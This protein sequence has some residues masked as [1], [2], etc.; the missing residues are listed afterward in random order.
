MSYQLSTT[1]TISVTPHAH[2]DFTNLTVGDPIS[3]CVDSSGNGN[4]LVQTTSGLTVTTY[5]TA[6][7]P[8]SAGTCAWFPGNAA[9]SGNCSFTS[10]SS[11][12]VFIGQHDLTREYN[13]WGAMVYMI[14][15][16]ANSWWSNSRG[17]VGL[18]KTGSA[19]HNIATNGPFYNSNEDFHQTHVNSIHMTQSVDLTNNKFETELFSKL[20]A[21]TPSNGLTTLYGSK[22]TTIQAGYASTTAT[23]RPLTH[24]YVGCHI[25][26][27]YTA[28]TIDNHWGGKCSEI[29][30]FDEP[31][32][33]AD[34]QIMDDYIESRYN[35]TRSRLVGDNCMNFTDPHKSKVDIHTSRDNPNTFTFPKHGGFDYYQGYLKAHFWWSMWVKF[36]PVL[37]T[38]TST[39]APSGYRYNQSNPA[40]SVYRRIM[41]MAGD[42]RDTSN[43]TDLSLRTDS[44]KPHLYSWTLGGG[45][46][47]T[48]TAGGTRQMEPDRWFHVL[49]TCVPERV[50]DPTLNTNRN[51]SHKIAVYVDGLLSSWKASSSHYSNVA[52]FSNHIRLGARDRTYPRHDSTDHHPGFIGQIAN[53][54][55]GVG[56]NPYGVGDPGMTDL[57]AS[58]N[59][60]TLSALPPPFERVNIIK[61][62]D[63]VSQTPG[64]ENRT[65]QADYTVVP[66]L[67]SMKL[68]DDVPL[69]HGKRSIYSGRSVS[70]VRWSQY[71][72]SGNFSNTDFHGL[73]GTRFRKS[74]HNTHLYFDWNQLSGVEFC[75]EWFQFLPDEPIYINSNGYQLQLRNNQLETLSGFTGSD[76]SGNSKYSYSYFDYN[77]I[78]STDGVE[79][80]DKHE[81]IYLGYNRISDISSLVNASTAN[82]CI[83]LSLEGNRFRELPTGV[84]QNYK[85]LTN[86]YLTSNSLTSIEGLEPWAPKLAQV[87]VNTQWYTHS[88]VDAGYEYAP[89][90]GFE[91]LFTSNAM[92]TI[93]ANGTKWET[94]VIPPMTGTNLTFLDFSHSNLTDISNL[95]TNPVA[96]V[97]MYNTQ[98]SLCADEV[99][100]DS[101]FL[102]NNPDLGNGSLG[103][104]AL[105]GRNISVFNRLNL[106]GTQL[107]DYRIFS[108]SWDH[109]NRSYWYSARG[110]I[111]YFRCSNHAANTPESLG[112]FKN[113]YQ[114]QTFYGGAYSSTDHLTAGSLDEMFTNTGLNKTRGDFYDKRF[115]NYM[116]LNY[117]HLTDV[118]WLSA[119][120]AAG[121][122]YLYL[123]YTPNLDYQTWEA[124]TP[125]LVALKQAGDI[126]L[127]RI[128]LTGSLWDR[129]HA[130]G[131]HKY[132]EYMNTHYPTNPS[133]HSYSRWTLS[134]RMSGYHYDAQWYPNL[135]LSAGDNF[136][137]LCD[138]VSGEGSSFSTQAQIKK[139]LWDA[140]IKMGFTA[141]NTDWH[142]YLGL[143]NVA[144]PSVCPRT[145]IL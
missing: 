109:P 105:S 47:L 34:Q 52:K 123:E 42:K 117:S 96:D 141:S 125:T 82:S 144:V 59:N 65:N 130:G 23:Y 106:Q 22:N 73:S 8:S 128:F 88:A 143:Y 3:A 66:Y 114:M 135:Y 32:S 76:F 139:D 67:S 17:Q 43:R 89:M 131:G 71:L 64:G 112:S 60:P 27:S 15:A 107:S 31:L 132:Q 44:G 19:I 138:G 115:C 80:L 12:I 46:S 118:S 103:A 35:T 20:S 99:P 75:R 51:G 68:N 145:T 77:N 4:N 85:N 87:R 40:T 136:Y 69:V 48:S 134:A 45:M 53:F 36:D 21:K 110:D 137:T 63:F 74:F 120:N 10:L 83:Y 101:I 61:T 119:D 121:I 79:F 7:A 140:G 116:Y 94:T 126:R 142:Q 58:T 72:N 29:F 57:T 55:Y 95:V 86:V 50:M 38:D 108:K 62:Q 81:R 70:N 14:D 37:W 124:V 39:V 6:A 26:N 98:G 91:V 78:T 133:G 54:T 33:V 16:T 24:M 49:V 13:Q 1:H 97:N 122:R 104:H 5:T 90:R 28:Q 2:Y 127:E 113:A 93:Y 100:Y 111:H 84:F 11:Q 129:K 41:T 92:R 56:D 30:I 9:L 102:N 25:A 18:Y